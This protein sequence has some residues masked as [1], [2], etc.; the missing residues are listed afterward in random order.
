MRVAKMASKA[1][2]AAD[3]RVERMVSG[4]MKLSYNTPS[5]M[6]IVTTAASTSSRVLDS[7]AWNAE[8]APWKLVSI[9]AGKFK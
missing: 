4:W 1:P 8:A 3:G 7:E 2:S 9:L 5:T 6:Y